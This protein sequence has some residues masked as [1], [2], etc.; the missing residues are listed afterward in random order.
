MRLGVCRQDHNSGWAY[1]KEKVACSDE[2]Y[3][4]RPGTQSIASRTIETMMKATLLCVLATLN[5]AL[6]FPQSVLPRDN[7]SSFYDWKPPGPS[8]G[9]K[10]SII[11]TEVGNADYSSA[12][13]LPHAQHLGKPRLS[14]TQW[15]KYYARGCTN[16]TCRLSVDPTLLKTFF[17]AAVMTNIAPNATKFSLEQ[18]RT[19]NILEHD[20]SL[21]YVFPL[22]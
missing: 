11:S 3:L 10:N 7:A 1:I 2:F 5:P 17:A 13:S 18:L 4:L 8:G 9:M 22:R 21:R 6:G 19:H 16:W 20:A 14:A 12:W 15:L